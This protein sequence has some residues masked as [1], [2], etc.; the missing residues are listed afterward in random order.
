MFVVFVHETAAD[1]I[2][3]NCKHSHSF[4]G[5]FGKRFFRVFQGNNWCTVC[6]FWGC[7]VCGGRKQSKNI[8]L[9]KTVLYSNLV[10]G[11]LYEL[12]GHY[13]VIDYVGYLDG[14]DNKQYLVF[15]QLSVYQKLPTIANCLK[16]FG[17]AFLLIKHLRNIF[18]ILFLY[19]SPLQTNEEHLIRY[20]QSDL[21]GL[22]LQY[23]STIRKF[24][25][26]YN[27]FV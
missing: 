26:W 14:S 13:P 16:S 1:K 12:I 9:V 7:D 17:N 20:L 24:L 4:A 23:A 10:T 11:V 2:E 15:V 22:C 19:I 25:F 27:I 21:C 18:H 8:S 6:H 3:E 5:M